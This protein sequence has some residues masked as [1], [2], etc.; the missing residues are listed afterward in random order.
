MTGFTPD[1]NFPAI[2]AEKG[3]ISLDLVRDLAVEHTGDIRII[4]IQERNCL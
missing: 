1:A 2:Y 3:I 4:S